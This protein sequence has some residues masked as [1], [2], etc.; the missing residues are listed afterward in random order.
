MGAELERYSFEHHLVR[1][2]LIACALV[3]V[4]LLVRSSTESDP[5]E[6]MDTREKPTPDF[7][8]SNVA[9]RMTDIMVALVLLLLFAPVLMLVSVLIFVL[10]GYPVF[11]VSKRYISVDQCVSIIK[12]RTMVTDAKSDKYRLRERFMRDGYLDIP[13]SCEVFTPIGRIL[14][15]TQIVEVLQLINVLVHGMS[16]IGN[17][18]LPRENI[19]LLKQFP[20]WE[21]R[22]YSPAGLSGISQVV[23]KLNQSP[24]ERLELESMYSDMYNSKHGNIF[25]CDIFI[26][27]YTV[28]LLLT[29]K[30]LALRDAKR[31]L[32]RMTSPDR[33]DWT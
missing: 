12:F 3:A 19:L 1:I 11:Y 8:L 6:V 30:H 10:E 22:F 5:V 15:R 32:N 24:E 9:K 29:G 31:L 28:R 20:G 23:G 25:L 26:A 4:I 16:L 14:E 18:P 21:R 2:I 33:P 13:P 7:K 27:Y 17:R